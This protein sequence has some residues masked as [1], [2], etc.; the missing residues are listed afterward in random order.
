MIGDNERMKYYDKIYKNRNVWGDKPNELLLKIYDQAEAGSE[1]LDLGCGQGRDSLFMLR[2][3]FKV[4]AVD[5]SAEGIKKIRRAIRIKNLPKTDIRLYCEDI[6]KFDITKNKYTIINAYNSLQFLLPKD[7]RKLIYKIKKALKNKGHII[8]SSFTTA[9][10]LY[11]KKSRCRCF[12]EPQEL[13]K[14]FSDFRLVLYREKTVADKGHPGCPGPH[15]HRIVQ[16]IAQ[17]K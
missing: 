17:K 16:V 6:Q 13:K 2:N 11:K 7:A 10:S 4:T 14:L 15:Q 12:F 9:D 5:N 1:F 8:I 3:G